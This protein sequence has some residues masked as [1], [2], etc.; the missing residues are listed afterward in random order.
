MVYHIFILRRA[1]YYATLQLLSQTST[2]PKAQS[3]QFYHHLYFSH[4]KAFPVHTPMYSFVT[5]SQTIASTALTTF[6]KALARANVK[7]AVPNDTSRAYPA[8]T[9]SIA[10]CGAHL[11]NS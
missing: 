11:T 6:S 1:M 9:P 7:P 10:R 4:I 3:N 5:I 2:A 8:S